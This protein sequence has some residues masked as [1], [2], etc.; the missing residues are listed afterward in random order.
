[1]KGSGNTL[2]C[3]SIGKHVLSAGKKPGYLKP[4]LSAEND[5]DAAFMKD[6]L[7]LDEP[8][9]LLSP[10]ISGSDIAGEIKKAVDKV[11]QDRDVVIIDGSP[12]QYQSSSKIAKELDAKLLIV[13]AY[14][15]DISQAI[16]SYKGFGQSLIGVIFNKVPEK[17][18]DRVTGEYAEQLAKESVNYLGAI[19]EDKALSAL[20]VGE[21]VACIDGKY[22]LGEE[23]SGDLIENLLLGAMTV[24]SGSEYFG[25][26]DN[27]A[28]I[29]RSERPDMQLAAIS[30]STKCLVL[31]GE[32]PP[33][34]AVLIKAE[35][36]EIPV[37]ATNESS[38]EIMERV[39]AV[40]VN[41]GLNQ[42]SKLA[43]FEKLVKQNINL[44]I[45]T[46]ELN[47]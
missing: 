32:T 3:A 6:V 37:I 2:I 24:D 43:R 35:E 10:V 26:K 28:A 36:K 25:R 39:E 44:E 40:M 17:R 31:T 15:E 9:E 41:P 4:V 30:T 13:E 19:Q 21:L 29:I 18:M 12:E 45:L 8:V 1:E 20:T 27:K 42:A 23:K 16:V 7:S 5:G 33:K 38:A 22:I 34:P 46:K 11:S 14:T 47:L